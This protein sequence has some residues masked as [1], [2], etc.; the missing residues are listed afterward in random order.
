MEL[1]KSQNYYMSLKNYDHE[2]LLNE[3]VV[4]MI[5]NEEKFKFIYKRDIDWKNQTEILDTVEERG[6]LFTCY[7]IDNETFEYTLKVKN[8]ISFLFSFKTKTFRN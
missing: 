8:V 3:L 4:E 7:F 2:K 5:N 1:A 6:L